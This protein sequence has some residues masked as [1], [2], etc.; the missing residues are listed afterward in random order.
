MSKFY[1]APPKVLPGDEVHALNTRYKRTKWEHGTVIRIEAHVV[2]GTRE[3]TYTLLYS[4][5]V[6]IDL[7]NTKSTFRIMYVSGSEIEPCTVEEV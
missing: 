4:Y 6:R 1:A 5:A 3:D 7:K 2:P